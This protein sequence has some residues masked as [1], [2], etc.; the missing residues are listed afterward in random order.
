M[1][2][3]NFQKR[4]IALI[5]Y[6]KTCE[7]KTIGIGK[8]KQK[9]ELGNLINALRREYKA[10][11]LQPDEIELLELM[12]MKWGTT[13]ADII[14][15]LKLWCTKNHCDL[16]QATQYS[17]LE[18]VVDGKII[19]YNIGNLLRGLRT[20]MRNGELSENQTKVLE[21]LGMVLY[22]RQTAVLYAHLIKY[23]EENGGLAN[24]PCS[25]I[26]EYNGKTRDIGRQASRLR[27]KFKEGTLDEDT[28][29]ILQPYGLWN[30]LET[31]QEVEPCDNQFEDSP[32]I[33]NKM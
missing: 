25:L 23:A 28:I 14:E 17:K 16:S 4:I 6:Y 20:A 32:E 12:G 22:P 19:E 5:E 26:Y 33:I 15:P 9:E 7:D 21:M 13:F 11:K 3:R 30:G 1:A 31:K 10:N 24:L 18:I 27:Q 2:K 29:D 8:I